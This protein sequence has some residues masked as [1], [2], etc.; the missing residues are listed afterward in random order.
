MRSSSATRS[1]TASASGPSWSSDSPRGGFAAIPPN[2]GG[3]AGARRA[4]RPLL[5]ARSSRSSAGRTGTRRRLDLPACGAVAGVMAR[6]DS[7]ARR[8]EGAGRPRG[9]HRRDQRPDGADRRQPLRAAQPDAA[10]TCCAPSPAPGTV[11][12]GART[13]KGDDTQRLGVQVRAGA[14]ARPTS[15]RARCTSA[16][17]SRCSSPTTPTC[18]RSCG[19]RSGRSCA[20]CSARARSSRARSGRSPTASSCICDETINPQ[21]EIDL[22]RVNVVVGFAPLKPAEFVID[23]DH[24]DLAAG[25]VTWRS[26]P[27]TPHRFDP[28]KAFMF[29][30]KWDGEYVAG[31]SKMSALQAHHRSGRPPRRRATRRTS[32][33]APGKSKYDAVTLERGVT[34]DH[35]FEDWANLVHSLDS[36]ISLQELPQ[37]HHRRRLQRG[38]RRRCSR[39]SSSAAGCPST[40]RCR[41]LD[42][43]TAAVA[44]ETIKL[45]LEG[46]ERDA[47]GHRADRDVA[48]SGRAAVLAALAGARQRARPGARA[49][50]R[51]AASSE[52]ETPAA[53][54]R[55]TAAARAAPRADRRDS[56]SP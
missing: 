35:A 12:W 1:P 48:V 30:V 37:G 14:A 50:P 55:A 15:S 33:R 6:T 39:T 31:L 8:V 54:R 53:R 56:S 9:R 29:R 10:S 16:R 42:A 5:P 23:H 47:V 3:P 26:S 4:R 46:W 32:A 13:L 38:Q 24:P 34:H 21:S 52:P 49:A 11:V 2:L 44:I 51:A 18:G 43:G 40:R 22:G 45:E 27:S 25:G 7:D 17:S 28:Y 36:P 19:W 20:A 41:A